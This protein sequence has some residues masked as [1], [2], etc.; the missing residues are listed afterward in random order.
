MYLD[1][2]NWIEKTNIRCRSNVNVREIQTHSVIV[3]DLT[4]AAKE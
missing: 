1:S 3:S 4:V 2:H